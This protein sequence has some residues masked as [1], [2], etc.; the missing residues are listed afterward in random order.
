MFPE[1]QQ[2]FLPA[3]S[4]SQFYLQAHAW[5]YVS[6]IIFSPIYVK[7]IFEFSHLDYTNS[8]A[9]FKFYNHLTL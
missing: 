3:E 7:N 4:C 9:C 8:V 6:F 2:M 1:L 5:F